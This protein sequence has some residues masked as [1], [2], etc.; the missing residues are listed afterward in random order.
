M[1]LKSDANMYDMLTVY[2]RFVVALRAKAAYDSNAL[3]KGPRCYLWLVF[4]KSLDDSQESASRREI[5]QWEF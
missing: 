4:P 5:A 1:K 3:R 2:M